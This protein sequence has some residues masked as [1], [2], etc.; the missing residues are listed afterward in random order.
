MIHLN[1]NSN[2]TPAQKIDLGNSMHQS[3]AILSK[4]LAFRYLCATSE[5]RCDI[6]YFAL[7]KIYKI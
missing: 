7:S 1:K 3:F 2:S 4:L 5:G 6:K